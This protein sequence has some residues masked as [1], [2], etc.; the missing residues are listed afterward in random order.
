MTRQIE[1][2]SRRANA[3]YNRLHFLKHTD[4]KGILVATSRIPRDEDHLRH[5]LIRPHPSTRCTFVATKFWHLMYLPLV[6]HRKI[7]GCPKRPAFSDSYFSGQAIPLHFGSMLTAYFKV[8]GFLFALALCAGALWGDLEW[9]I[10]GAVLAFGLTLLFLVIFS[11]MRLGKAPQARSGLVRRSVL[12]LVLASA[13]G[14]FA[15]LA[16]VGEQYRLAAYRT[17]NPL[18]I[19]IELPGRVQRCPPAA[20]NARTFRLLPNARSCTDLYVAL[21]GRNAPIADT[22]PSMSTAAFVRT[23]KLRANIDR[24]EPVFN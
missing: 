1:I 20:R 6:P 13:V 9:P 19:A 17:G 14:V 7:F 11:W 5:D 24:E 15:L 23:F 22:D 16:G 21:Y 8:W 3:G 2:W 12:L 4:L 18:G 10:S